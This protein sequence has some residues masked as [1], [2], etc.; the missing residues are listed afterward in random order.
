MSLPS[1]VPSA[2]LSIDPRR[3]KTGR[4]PV[5]PKRGHGVDMK[6]Q[7]ILDLLLAGLALHINEPNENIDVTSLV[8]K[9]IP[10]WSTGVQY[11]LN[12]FA[13]DL[14]RRVVADTQEDGWYPD[15]FRVEVS[16]VR[17]AHFQV[18][19]TCTWISKEKPKARR[20]GTYIGRLQLS[21]SKVSL[22][23]PG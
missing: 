23:R 7:K 3:S 19:V 6:A 4:K 20:T 2:T 15:K 13:S 22:I 1:A 18:K 9:P 11:L 12:G 5:K 17:V 21:I 14:A 8:D 16:A 10:R